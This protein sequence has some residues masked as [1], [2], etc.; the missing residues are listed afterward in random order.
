MLKSDSGCGK[1]TRG[2]IGC[3]YQFDSLGRC[4]RAQDFDH[5]VV[6]DFDDIGELWHGTLLVRLRRV[7]H[8]NC[9]WPRW[10]WVGSMVRDGALAS[11]SYL[12]R[13]CSLML[14]VIDNY[15]SFV[16]NL[17]RHFERLG[18]ETVVVRNDAVSVA[19][20]RRMRPG[21]IVI[22][23]GPCAP[24]DAGVSLE[25]VQSMHA[26]VPILGVCLGHQAIGEA[27]G[28]CVVRAPLPVHGQAS[29][30]AH[31]CTGL[32]AEVPS[33]FAAARYHSL[34]VEAATL[35]ETLRPTAWTADGVL[36]AI[37]HTRYPVYGVQFH[38]ESILTECGYEILANFL[39]LAGMWRK[40][41][42]EIGEMNELL[43][44]Q[45]VSKLL[46]AG[47]VTF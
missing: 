19:D 12:L 14:L 42:R 5:F 11:R 2:S 1:E 18:Q 39:K 32:F 41:F 45:S 4:F 34:V 25:L 13:T 23:P 37:E 36:M 44:P 3:R 21:A 9:V 46:P 47:P 24:Q 26:E 29:S 22:S 20:V 30:V 15:D 8:N 43:K 28:G 40:Q 31:D 17:A 27:L 16:H 33:P 7:Y 10:H 35:P 38:P 6:D